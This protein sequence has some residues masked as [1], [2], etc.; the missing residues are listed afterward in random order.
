[1]G[2]GGAGSKMGQRVGLKKEYCNIVVLFICN[3][4]EVRLKKAI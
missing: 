2:V 1:M 4:I 3:H